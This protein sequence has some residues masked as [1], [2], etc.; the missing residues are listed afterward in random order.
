MLKLLK[1]AQVYAPQPMGRQDV[2]IAGEKILRWYLV[3]GVH[4]PPAP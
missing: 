1:N 2:L 4:L 3:H